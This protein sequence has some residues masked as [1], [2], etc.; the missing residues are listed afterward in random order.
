MVEAFRD[1][2]QPLEVE[3]VRV[4]TTLNNLAAAPCSRASSTL[5]GVSATAITSAP[6]ARD[7]DE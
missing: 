6:A 2:P 4:G 1:D 3:L 5:A 7:L